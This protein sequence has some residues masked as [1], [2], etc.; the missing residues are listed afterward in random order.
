MIEADSNRLKIICL[1][2]ALLLQ[3]LTSP[4]SCWMT[5]EGIPADVRVLDCGYSFERR[6]FYL[7]VQHPSF[8]PVPEGE[9]IPSHYSLLV[10]R[11]SPP[12]Q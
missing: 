11:L 5:A 8:D 3:M 4:P 6:A 12:E 9:I 2:P 1:P 7:V 10:Q